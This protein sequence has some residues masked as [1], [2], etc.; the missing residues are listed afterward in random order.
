MRDRSKNFWEFLTG[1]CTCTENKICG[2][3]HGVY[4]DLVKFIPKLD[5]TEEAKECEYCG[6]DIA[7]RNPTGDCDHLYYPENANK[8]YGKEILQE[9]TAL[10]RD[11]AQVHTFYDVNDPNN[12]KEYWRELHIKRSLEAQ[13]LLH[14]LK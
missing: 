5:N 10:I 8:N 6:E 7:I 9:C 3:H 4:G 11:H 2:N 13:A 12:T 14:K 1:E